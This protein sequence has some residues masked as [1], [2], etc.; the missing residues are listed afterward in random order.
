M[1]SKIRKYQ[2]SWITKSILALT[3]LS[4]M[5]LFGISSYV[6]SAGKN[7]AVI[8]VD[9]LEILQ[10]EMNVKLNNNIRKAQNMFG[11]SIEINDAMRKNILSNLVK[12]NLTSMIIAREAQK[13]GVSISDE[14]IQQIIATQ[15]EFM[16][17]SGR[18]SPEA[19][20]RQLSYFDMS[21]QEYI[22]ELRQNILDRHLVYSPVTGVKFP[23]FM[24]DY[25]AKIENQ[26]KVFNYVEV[27]PSSLKIDRTISDEEIEQY[28]QDFAPQFEE[29]ER[30]DVSFIE[31]KVSDLSKGYIPS[32]DEIKDY[33]KENSD[34]YI[35]PEKR[36]IL[37]M[38]FDTEEKANEAFALL[39]KGQDFYQVAADKANQDKETTNLGNVTTDSLLPELTEDA[40]DAKLNQVVG[41]INS[42]FGW[43]ILKI[44]NITPKKETPLSSV[45]NK[46]ISLLQQEQ[47][48]DQA[49]TV[50]SEIEDKIGAGSDL[51]SISEEYKSKIYQVKGLKD[52]GNYSSLSNSK[53][54]DLVTSSDFLE[55]AFSY[56]QNEISQTVETE[57]GFVLLSVNNIQDAHIKDLDIVKPEI[58]K[59]WTENEKSAIAQEIVND[60]VADLDNGENLV[61]IA[62]R[63][64]IK[65]K[66]TSPLKRGESFAGLNTIQTTEAYQTPLNEYK[67][68]T[69]AGSTIIV[70]P[71]KVIN[72]TKAV[73]KKQKDDI[74]LRMQKETEQ[75][76]ASELIDAYA[77]DMDVRVK[78]RLLGLED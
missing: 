10:D 51:K 65:L 28:Y 59:I 14:L 37:Q 16:D 25:I 57:D 11:D 20:R 47:A 40:F 5:S 48:Y 50:V 27:N 36:Q 9:K 75:N 17:A 62:N 56:N 41:P 30:R 33:Y 29:A 58:I 42:E 4:F 39:Q 44:T 64:N 60:V 31:L 7:R 49:L 32:E 23:Q 24:N 66:T 77:K 76:L 38:V 45:R 1:I 15:P 26:Q 43:H 12:E 46:I 54:K 78:Y 13:E 70:T 73:S 67:L 8:K 55:N 71:T 53:F 18:F 34:T 63:F 69:N 3:A 68:L 6:S 19:L 35:T 72:T 52:D 74:N 22:N 21:E 61:D 2:D